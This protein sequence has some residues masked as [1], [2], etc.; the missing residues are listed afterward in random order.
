MEGEKE[1]KNIF[2]SIPCFWIKMCPT[3]PLSEEQLRLQPHD[4]ALQTECN[5]KVT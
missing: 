4:L 2:T 1:I 3:G 5:F